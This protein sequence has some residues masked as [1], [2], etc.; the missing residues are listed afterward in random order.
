MHASLCGGGY[1]LKA[2]GSV[3]SYLADGLFNLSNDTLFRTYNK[4][5]NEVFNK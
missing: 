4:A 2:P 3:A 5:S 1:L